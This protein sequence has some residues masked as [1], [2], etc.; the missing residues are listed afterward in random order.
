MAVAAAR[1]GL[2]LHRSWDWIRAAS[3]LGLCGGLRRLR[4]ERAGRVE[5]WVPADD[6]RGRIVSLTDPGRATLRSAAVVHLRGV[7]QHFAR[8]LDDAELRAAL[9]RERDEPD[10]D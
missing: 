6:A 7:Q 1:A 4:V 8:H 10:G 5:R 9:R 2:G 3:L